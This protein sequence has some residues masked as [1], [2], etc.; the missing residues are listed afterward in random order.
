MF[1]SLQLDFQ[2][3]AGLGQLLFAGLHL[4]R[5]LLQLLLLFLQLGLPIVQANLFGIP[6]FGLQFHGQRAIALEADVNTPGANGVV[7]VQ[8]LAF[9]DL[10]IHT[11]LPFGG[12]VDHPHVISIA[13]KHQVLAG[14][15]TRQA[16]QPASLMATQDRQATTQEGFA[17]V[18][19]LGLKTQQGEGTPPGA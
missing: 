1:P 14:N 16:T 9:H 13:V 19:V 2:L 5:L 17:Q 4:G 11:R 15:G 7:I 18:L 3:L 12:Q 6:L 8:A 10:P